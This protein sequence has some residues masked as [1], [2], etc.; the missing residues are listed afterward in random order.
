MSIIINYPFTTAGNYTYDT[1]KV[2]IT[3]GVG[4]LKINDDPNQ[5][6]TEDFVDD[7]GFTYDNTKAEFSSGKVQQKSQRVTDSTCGATYT[8]SVDLNW[9]DGTLTG[10]T[11]GGAAV[12][13]GKLD[14]KYNDTRYVDYNADLNADSRQVGAVKMKITPNYSGAPASTQYFISISAAANDDINE[15]AIL[16][17]TGSGDL[18]VR[19]KDS[20]GGFIFFSV[21]TSG[22][23]PVSG[24]EY[25]IELN[26]DVTTGANRLFLDGVQQGP[27]DTNTGTRDSNI[28]LFRVGS[29]FDA[30]SV[31]NFLIDDLIYFSTV[32]HTANYTPGYTVAEADYLASVVVLPE[33]AY[34]GAGAIQAFTAFATIEG[35]APRYTLNSKYWGGAAWISSDNTYAQATSAADINTNIASFA[36]T[37][38]IV[39]RT[40][41]TDI[42]TQGYVDNLVLTYTGQ[43]YSTANP[44]I[45][46]IGTIRLDGLEGFVETSTKSGSDEIKYI[47]KKGTDY[48]Y[49]SG[50]AWVVSNETYAQSNTAAEIETN[51]ASFASIG[52]VSQVKLFLHSTAGSTTPQIDNLQITYNFFGADISIVDKCIIWAYSIND[53]GTVNQSRVKAKLSVDTVRYKDNVTIIA[54]DVF[55]VPNSTGY[56]EME[57]VDTANMTG[58]PQYTFLISGQDYNRD[59]PD[60]VSANFWDLT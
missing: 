16:H 43:V 3:G 5:D 34:S 21:F 40:I 4:K 13:N 15:I 20:T 55:A 41:F 51:K 36:A 18:D 24:T 31:S 23:A 57:L 46:I 9:G 59:V 49:W 33:F 17:V 52:I 35:D 60:E 38:S 7:T 56:W 25:E 14:L 45:E 8:N 27:T 48:Y 58:T 32:Q 2:E 47:L 12:S 42:N 54:K 1:D 19:I 6:F 28:G 50:S 29:S 44:I 30:T 37:D 53:D 11:I 39:C 26:W 10:N 22:W